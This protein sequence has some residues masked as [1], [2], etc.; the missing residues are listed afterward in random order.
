MQLLSEL[1]GFDPDAQVG[2]FSNRLVPRVGNADARFYLQDESG[3]S[4]LMIAANVQ[5]SEEVLGV[6][7]RKGPDVNQKSM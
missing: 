6:L 3:W 2:F 1:R 7:L 4:P 5:D